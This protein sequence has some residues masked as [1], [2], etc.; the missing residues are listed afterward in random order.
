MIS[1]IYSYKNW[2]GISQYQR[3]DKRIVQ[4]VEYII[5]KLKEEK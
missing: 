4:L 5:F 3:V 2:I 1:E